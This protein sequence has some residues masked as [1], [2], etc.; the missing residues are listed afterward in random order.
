MS[1]SDVTRESESHPSVQW[2]SWRIPSGLRS[3]QKENELDV[4]LHLNF[5]ERFTGERVAATLE[6]YHKKITG[7]V[8]RRR[9]SQVLYNPCLRKRIFLFLQGTGRG[10]H[11]SL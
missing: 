5:A 1:L 9:Y 2:F 7:F 4:G 6:N 10:V 8:M 3:W 11:P